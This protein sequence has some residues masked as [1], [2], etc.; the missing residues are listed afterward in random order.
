MRQTR[1][2]CAGTLTLYCHF[3]SEYFSILFSLLFIWNAT[4]LAIILFCGR[5]K[6][7][8]CY[9]KFVKEDMRNFLQ[10]KMFKMMRHSG[11]HQF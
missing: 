2:N 11:D 5:R 4:E 9:E 7:S 6:N 3:P 1:T 8:C 10:Q